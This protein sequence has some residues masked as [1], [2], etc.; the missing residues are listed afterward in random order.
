[1]V[2]QPSTKIQQAGWACRAQKSRDAGAMTQRRLGF[3]THATSEGKCQ[4]TGGISLAKSATVGNPAS[5]RLQE[6]WPHGEQ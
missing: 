5:S 4:G 1:M 2:T 3:V 6:V